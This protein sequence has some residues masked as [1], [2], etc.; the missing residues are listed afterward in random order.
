MGTNYYSL[1]WGNH[2][3]WNVVSYI[4][5]FERS[6]EKRAGRKCDC[7]SGSMG[8]PDWLIGCS[9]VLCP[10]YMGI[11]CPKPHRNPCDLEWW[12]CNLWGINCRSNNGLSI[13]QEKE[14][15][16]LAT[17]GY[18]STWCSFGAGDRALGKFYQ[19]RSIWWPGHPVVLR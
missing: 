12:D 2:C 3:I 11:L 14:Y 17:T 9:I 18:L 7:R 10:V 16:N 5:K 4:F 8:H 19:S 1:V 13:R 6:Q 15:F